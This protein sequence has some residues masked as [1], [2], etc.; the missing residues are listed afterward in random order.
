MTRKKRIFSI[1]EAVDVLHQIP[2]LKRSLQRLE[3]QAYDSLK[4]HEKK[5]QTYLKLIGGRDEHDSNL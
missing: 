1:D 2:V 4:Y 3:E 5:R